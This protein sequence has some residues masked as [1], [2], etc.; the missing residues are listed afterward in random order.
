M[1]F[2]AEMYAALGM[3]FPATIS[4][5]KPAAPCTNL[6]EVAIFESCV[7]FLLSQF[8]FGMT[9]QATGDPGFQISTRWS[10]SFRNLGPFLS[11]HENSINFTCQIFRDA[12]DVRNGTLASINDCVIHLHQLAPRTLLEN[13][14]VE[15]QM[16]MA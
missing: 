5:K 3:R 16:N 15:H 13:A 12:R 7:A 2:N 9:Q 10:F 6:H 14:R 8:F 11:C 1:A 4:Q